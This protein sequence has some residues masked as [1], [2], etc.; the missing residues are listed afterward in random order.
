MATCETT[1]R[2]K[3][4]LPWPLLRGGM[5]YIPDGANLLIGLDAVKVFGS[6]VMKD[7]Q[8]M[9]AYG[10]VGEVIAAAEAC[11]VGM[12]TWK[13]AVV[14]GNTEEDKEV[15]VVLSA[16]DI[17][18]KDTL[19][20]IGKKVIE[21]DPQDTFELGEEDGRVV[22]SG[23]IDGQKMYAISDDVVALVG[24]DWLETF[25]D[26]LDGKGKTA[27]EGS[28]NDVLASVDQSKHIYFGMAATADMQ[29]GA[30]ETLKYVTGTVYLSAGISVAVWAEFADSAAAT[31]VAS[32]AITQFDDVKGMAGMF[33]IPYGVVENVNIEAKGAAAGFSVSAAGND[34]EQLS[35]MIRKQLGVPSDATS[36]N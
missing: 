22:V 14:G 28:L 34:L 9:L 20:C 33:G 12:S 16:T 11:N 13:Y 17:G 35:V 5:R 1:A 3:P 18:K 2:M 19:D 25:E 23:G 6:A 8:D 30:T 4:L 29:E 10:D 15:V 21:K 36:Q 32:Q 27:V 31:A 24:A 26:L 7:N